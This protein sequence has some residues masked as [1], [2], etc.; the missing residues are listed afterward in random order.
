MASQADP[1]VLELI[2]SVQKELAE[3]L[4]ARQRV[5][6]TP[7]DH[8]RDLTLEIEQIRK[9]DQLKVTLAGLEGA[10]ERRYS[11]LVH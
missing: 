8:D 5:T 3:V 10:L 4:E 6:D 11:R 2:E 9:I 1:L 7:S